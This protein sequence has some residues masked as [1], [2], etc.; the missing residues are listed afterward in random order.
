[1]GF[2]HFFIYTKIL[3]MRTK[4]NPFIIFMLCFAN[5]IIPFLILATFIFATENFSNPDEIIGLIFISSFSV[6]ITLITLAKLTSYSVENGELIIKTIFRK[7]RIEL[8][9]ITKISL[10]KIFD[11]SSIPANI[12]NPKGY[13]IYYALLSINI[14]EVIIFLK[15]GKK[16][17]FRTIMYLN[18]SEFIQQISSASRVEI[19]SN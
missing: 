11:S 13:G 9:D 18:S 10:R 15:N 7:K 6:M 12:A 19:S 1:M 3:N 14:S 17:D 16:I 5:L 8:S 4:F 2:A